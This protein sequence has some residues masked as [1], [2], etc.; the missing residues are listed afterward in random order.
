MSL[1]HCSCGEKTDVIDTRCSYKRL[2]R[3]R[4]CKQNHRFSTVEVPLEAT[5][6]LKE[7]IL[8]ASRQEEA[9]DSDMVLYVETQIEEIMLGTPP[10]MDG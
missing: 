5:K 2:R 4:K 10:I 1:Y 3:R 8:W 9:F 6:Q 7:L